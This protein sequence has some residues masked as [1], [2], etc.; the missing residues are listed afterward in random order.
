MTTF[1]SQQIKVMTR[2]MS[3]IGTLQALENPPIS[4]RGE[5]LARK[6]FFVVHVPSQKSKLAYLVLMH[7]F[8]LCIE[9]WNCSGGMIFLFHFI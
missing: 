7:R 1:A 9:F 2:T 3:S 8:C 4:L 6:T 5:V